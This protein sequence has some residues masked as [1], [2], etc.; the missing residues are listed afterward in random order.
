MSFTL[1]QVVPWGRSFAEY[2]RMFALS[3][4]DLGLRILGCGDGPASFNAALTGRG[5]NVTSVDPLYQFSAADIRRRIDATYPTV[6]A[7]TR[8]N[9]GE[10]V[11]RNPASVEELGRLRMTAMNDFLADYAPGNPRYVCG[12]L[13]S[14]PF[15]DREFDLALCSHFLFLYSEQLSAEFHLLALRELL[16]VA[17]EVRVFPLLELGARPSRHLAQ[18]LAGLATEHCLAETV[19][20]DYEF[21][22]GGNQLLRLRAR[23]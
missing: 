5:G 14:L 22:R 16:R 17:A 13:P 21:Q 1:D 8:K 11:W 12:Q 15:R 19:T 4:A 10:F 2:A 3:D 9:A 23:L 18:V 6:M 7:Q 20:V